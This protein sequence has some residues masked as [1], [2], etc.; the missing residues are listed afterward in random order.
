MLFIKLRNKILLL[1]LVLTSA[2]ILVAFAAIYLITAN[3]MQAENTRKLDTLAGGQFSV[4]ASETSGDIASDAVAV[5]RQDKRLPADYSLSFTVQTDSSGNIRAV[6]S[7]ID[8]PENTYQ[9]AVES[10]QRKG[11][12]RGV[13]EINQR[14]WLYAIAPAT[15][16]RIS[17]DNGVPTIAAT[18]DGGSQISFLDITG[19]MDTLR[20]LAVTFGIVGFALLVVIFGISRVFANRSIKPIAQAWD[21]QKQFIAD[22][23][24]ELKTPLSIINANYDVLLAN[25]DE[26]IRSQLKWFSYMKIGTDRM[27]SLIHTLLSLA[28]IEDKSREV[29]KTSFAISEMVCEIVQQM[30]AALREKGITLKS[31]IEPSIIVHQDRGLVAQVFAILYDNAIKYTEANGHIEVSV[32]KFK[33]HIAC[34]VKNSGK[35]ISPQDLSRIFDR[36]YRADPSRTADS[37]GYGLGLAIAKS[38]MDKL[39]GTITASSVENESTTFTFTLS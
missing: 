36:F 7:L 3:H 31:S 10:V 13:I 5:D 26:T 2:V 14:K 11:G 19:S 29:H 20:Q 30:E 34:T 22:A 38:C 23:S 8:L 25:P 6:D 35:G 33:R 28:S 24:H 15:Q 37:G 27:T 4:K 17:N 16:T 12:D 9:Q 39:G 21:K 1:N 18:Q 32:Q